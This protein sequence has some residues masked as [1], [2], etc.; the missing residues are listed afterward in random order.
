MEP[1]SNPVRIIMPFGTQWEEVQVIVT[2]HWHILTRSPQVASIVGPRPQMVAK[3]ARNLADKL[4]RFEFPR[5]TPQNWLIGL[6]Q[7]K[8]IFPCGRCHICKF[9]NRT[10]V[11]TDADRQKTYQIKQFINCNTTRVLFILECRCHKFYVGKTKQPLKVHIGEHLLSIRGGDDD[12]PIAQHFAQFHK[13]Q[14]RA[15]R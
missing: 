15:L 5:S 1:S 11:F 3:R 4:V 12:T 8:G 7:M 6:P 9:V 14:P 10:G 2:K 13:G